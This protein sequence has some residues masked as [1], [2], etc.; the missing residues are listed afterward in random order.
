VDKIRLK[1]FGKGRS[2][3]SFGARLRSGVLWDDEGEK[4][5]F[6]GFGFGRR[7][8]SDYLCTPKSKNGGI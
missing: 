4:L 8:L 5:I 1:I 2:R 6:F 7:G 3:I